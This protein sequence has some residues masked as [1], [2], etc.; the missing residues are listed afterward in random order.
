MVKKIMIVIIIVILVLIIAFFL[1]RAFESMNLYFPVKQLEGTPR[2]LGLEYEDVYFEASDGVKLNGWFVPSKKRSATMLYYHG[3]AG[4][5]S[6]RLPIIKMFNEMGI[7]VFIFDYRGYGKSKGFPSE[8]GIYRDGFAAYDYLLSRPD[9]DK[10]KLVLYGKSIGA[11]VATEVLKRREAK[12]LITE[13]AF[14]SAPDMAGELYPILPLKYVIVSKY[15]SLSNIKTLDLPV[16]VIH[17]KDDEIIPFSHGKR[18]FEAAREPKKVLE[19]YGGHNYAIILEPE[20]FSRVIRQFLKKQGIYLEE[21]QVEPT[22]YPNV[23]EFMR[24]SLD[25]SKDEERE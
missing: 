22:G 5:I 23:T 4:N 25:I 16:L 20:K 7:D 10:G 15:D 24:G 21:K 6:H 12:A 3:N 13:G 9:V 1:L 14:T 19:V 11:A 8:E 18:I 2:D 17:A